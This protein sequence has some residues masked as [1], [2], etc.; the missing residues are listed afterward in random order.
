MTKGD[1]AMNKKMILISLLLLTALVC[2]T[3]CSDQWEAPYASL[4]QLGATVSVRFDA[5]GGLFAG[6]S[7]VT[8]TD[9]YDPQ[10]AMNTPEGKGFYLLSPDDP[11]RREGSFSVSKIGY[12]L[13]GWY[14]ERTL[15]VDDRG[16]PLDDYG[17]PCAT[18][19]RPQGY[20]YSG[21]WDFGGDA[22]LLA[23]IHSGSSAQA[24]LTLYAGWVPYIKYEIL[25]VDPATGTS[26][27]IASVMSVDLQIPQWSE[28]TGKLDRKDFPD[29]EGFTFDGAYT[30]PDLTEAI[31]ENM[32]GDIYVDYAT[33]TLSVE[34]V[35]IYTTWLDGT[36]FRIYTAQQFCSNARLDGNYMICADLDFEGQVWP[37]LLVKGKFTGTIQGNSHTF[38]N[39]SAIQGDNS[40]VLGGLFGSLEAT[41]RITDLNLENVTVTI[42]AG[43]R[44]QGGTYGLLAGSVSEGAAFQNVSITGTLLISEDCYPQSDYTIGLLCGAGT[45]E[46]V[47][48]TI[49]CRP[50]EENSDKITVEIHDDGSVTVTFVG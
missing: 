32:D 16:N 17:V 13:A 38:S 36:W 31:T 24:D 7:D 15:R 11:Q 2:V 4:D 44:L 22:L 12:F 33:G 23:D 46:G 20:T 9:V 42:A 43:S 14:T 34:S 41:A 8:I 27:S 26:E 50:A 18:S 30:S 5:N 29:R 21:L 49:D 3:G 37:P 47:Q 1:D 39:I 25:A 48:Y 10:S 6:T 35:Q 40:Q 19:G 28:K 45:A